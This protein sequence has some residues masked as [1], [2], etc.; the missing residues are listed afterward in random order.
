MGHLRDFP[1]TE[2]ASGASQR[3]NLLVHVG[4]SSAAQVFLFRLGKD[5]MTATQ[6]RQC[7]RR[8]NQ[9]G[10]DQLFLKFRRGLGHKRSAGVPDDDF[11]SRT[12]SIGMINNE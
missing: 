4:E 6:L 12:G 2:E 8:V 7:F 11:R 5:L 10:R 3:T 9:K 1:E